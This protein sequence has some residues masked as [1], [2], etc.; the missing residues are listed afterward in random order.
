MVQSGE[1]NESGSSSKVTCWLSITAFSQYMPLFLYWY[2][3]QLPS[4]VIIVSNQPRMQFPCIICMIRTTLRCYLY[5]VLS[6]LYL[7]NEIYYKTSL[8]RRA[9]CARI[10]WL[11]PPP[12]P[13]PP[14]HTHT[15][16]HT[17]KD[18]KDPIDN[19]PTLVKTMPWRWIG[20]KTL[21]EPM[22]VR[23]HGAYMRH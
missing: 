3:H 7:T 14:P 15:H 6:K 16:T 11:E 21:S 13:P 9:S 2:E 5:V 1:G 10:M 17:P 18:P 20:D 8:E 4:L 23:F 22:L 19:S 12:P